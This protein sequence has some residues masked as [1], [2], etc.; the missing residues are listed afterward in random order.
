MGDAT[1]AGAKVAA[2]APRSVIKYFLKHFYKA[3]TGSLHH[4]KTKSGARLPAGLMKFKRRTA[5]PQ[6]FPEVS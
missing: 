2:E 5:K 6:V 3:K 4:G 1:A